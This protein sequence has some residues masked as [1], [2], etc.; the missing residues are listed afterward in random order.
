MYSWHKLYNPY[1]YLILGFK[2]F[3]RTFLNCY[4]KLGTCYLVPEP[5]VNVP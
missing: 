1:R 4:V 2:I 3:N 5:M